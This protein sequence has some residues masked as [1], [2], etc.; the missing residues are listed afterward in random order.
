MMTHF[1]IR[2]IHSL[3]GR[4]WLGVGSLWAPQEA[5]KKE[6][7]ELGDKWPGFSWARFGFPG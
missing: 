7:E 1:T 2:L 3:L 5:M 4:N 6:M